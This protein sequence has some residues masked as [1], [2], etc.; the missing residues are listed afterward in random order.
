MLTTFYLSGRQKFIWTTQPN[1]FP[2]LF[3]NS[4][5]AFTPSWIQ[6]SASGILPAPEKDQDTS[7]D[8]DSP[9]MDKSKFSTTTKNTFSNIS[10]ISYCRPHDTKRDTYWPERKQIVQENLYHKYI[11]QFVFNYVLLSYNFQY[12]PSKLFF[13]NAGSEIYQNQNSVHMDIFTADKQNTTT[14]E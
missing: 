3:C 9:Y 2:R 13:V 1:Q 6:I 11:I 12:L 8:W 5:E 14:T 10:V 7:P 4:T